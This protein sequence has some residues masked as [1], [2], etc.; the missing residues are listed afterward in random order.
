M[1]KILKVFIFFSLIYTLSNAKEHKMFQTVKKEEATLVK[2]DSTKHF[3]SIC[4]MHLSKF[5]KTNHVSTFKNGKKEQY[6]SLHCQASANLK[7]IKKIEVV[8]TNSL[9]LIDT[10][11]AFYV[12]NSSK[13]GTMSPISKYAFSSKEE[14][15][16][17]QKK[18]GGQ[19]HNFKETLLLA[20]NSLA[21]DDI[22]I[23]K[24]RVMMAKKGKKIY[25]SLCKKTNLPKF[26]TIT[27]AKRYIIDTSLCKN[28]KG[29]MTQALAI[30]LYNPNLAA[31]QHNKIKISKNEKCPVC[32][33]FVSKYPKWLASITIKSGK[34]YYFDG[35]KDMMKFYFKPSKYDNKAKKE[36]FT[37]LLTRDYYTLENINAKKAFFVVGSNI[38]G[39]MG[40]ELIA[41]KQK[42]NAQ[43]FL[44]DHFAKKILTFDEIQASMLY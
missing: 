16:V 5:Y 20:Q 44:E 19:I 3:C 23:K 30:Y 36:D 28:L 33:M 6:C 11:N 32:G 42:K 43:K 26:N 22:H 34:I 39:P 10:K 9:K 13:K 18:F 12:V 15:K 2:K 38:Y 40:E 35:V 4:G 14:A 31:H 8:D 25:H 24:K 29:K 1:N 7:Q 21:K 37:K 17:F 27:D 41:F